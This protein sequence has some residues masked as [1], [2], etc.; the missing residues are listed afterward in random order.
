M[1]SLLRIK[2]LI[3]L[4]NSLLLFNTY[5]LAQKN[6]KL[7]KEEL[8]ANEIKA[9]N[10]SLCTIAY[11]A[12]DENYERNILLI[13]SLVSL[14]ASVNCTCE[15][16]STQFDAVN[17]L[18]NAVAN[19]FSRFFFHRSSHPYNESE[20]IVHPY[21][22]AALL[23]GSKKSKTLEYIVTKYKA[24]LNLPSENNTVPLDIV[25][26]RNDLEEIK[27]II[28]LGADPMKSSICTIDQE[29]VEYLLTKGV[30]VSQLN[31]NF[32]AQH[33]EKPTSFNQPEKE[34]LLLTY[35]KKYKPDLS[36]FTDLR[37]P[38]KLKPTTLDTLYATGL[39][40]NKEDIYSYLNEA[41][42][43]NFIPYAKIFI[44]Y[45]ANLSECTIIGCPIEL[46]IDRSTKEAILLIADNGGLKTTKKIYLRKPEIC[47]LLLEKGLP[48][49]NLQIECLFDYE[50]ILKKVLETY[51]PILSTFKNELML[52]N[53]KPKIFELLVE[54]GYKPTENFMTSVNSWKTD[55]TAVNYLKIYIANNFKFNQV[56]I[57]EQSIRKGDL[58]SV[59]VLIENGFSKSDVFYKG[60][61]PFQY[62]SRLGKK[63]IV[64]FLK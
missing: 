54:H 50:V 63:E 15:I 38:K 23:A 14:G 26:S 24:D 13:D 19:S 29:T 52:L 27:W 12:I 46:A 21:T 56:A 22:P 47:E 3:L 34:T 59:K 36:G 2:F 10:K 43:S 55:G 60:E 42:S 39:P 31:W 48:I 6:K 11:T 5:C 28:Q 20:T 18:K 53:A 9:C 44:K 4:I 62:A 33:V 35:I 49:D 8:K 51:H 58:A 25:F 7:S 1:Q 57:M 64:D 17:Y 37:I 45:K 41:N 32:I 40:V 16:T 30:T 61:T